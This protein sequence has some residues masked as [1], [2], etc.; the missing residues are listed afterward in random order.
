MGPHVPLSCAV[1]LSTAAV[2]VREVSG[3]GMPETVSVAGKDLRLNGMGMR[4]VHLF[5]EVYV[6]G[7]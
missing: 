7:L 6:V 1:A 5:F 3:V 4:K 2:P